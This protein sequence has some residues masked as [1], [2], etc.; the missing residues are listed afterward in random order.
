VSGTSFGVCGICEWKDGV[1]EFDDNAD[2]ECV[3]SDDTDDDDTDD[4]GESAEKAAG[5]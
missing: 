5:V 4:G 3:E 2:A 1:V